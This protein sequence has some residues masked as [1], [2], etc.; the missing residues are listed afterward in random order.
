MKTTK[1]R[2]ATA[3]IKWVLY[4]WMFQVDASKVSSNLVH[5]CTIL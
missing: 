1:E 3:R 2:T 5:L 4:W